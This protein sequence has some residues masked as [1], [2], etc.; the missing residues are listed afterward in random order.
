[1][2]RPSDVAGGLACACRCPACDRA[3]IARNGGNRRR[4]HFAHHTRTECPG[5]FESAIHR[6]A[7]QLV[8]ESVEITLPGW[9]GTAEMPNP[10]V[11]RGNNGFVHHGE[12][13]DIA[14]R[15]TPLRGARVELAVG[16]FRPDVVA[17]DDDGELL[18]EIKVTHAVGANKQRLVRSDSHR[19]FEIDLSRV[20]TAE[21][22]DSQ[23]FEHLVLHE[24]RNRIW[25][26]FPQAEAA[27]LAARDRLS[28]QVSDSEIVHPIVAPPS[29][30][31]RLLPNR[32]QHKALGAFQTAEAGHRIWHQGLGVGT[33]IGRAMT[34]TPIFQV[35]FD[36]HG[37]RTIVL[38]PNGKNK[39]WQFL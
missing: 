12:K 32:I 29:V 7:K 11:L 37:R 38:E 30:R 1:M 23:R 39:T 34:T 13:I 10:P 8:C 6:M 33:V 17:I 22:E 31:A 15:R 21:A 5:A 3:L 25:L 14:F 20:T 9:D 19:M 28:Q 35:D 24:P 27:W 2:W 4:P 36:E 18:I 16:A 26:S